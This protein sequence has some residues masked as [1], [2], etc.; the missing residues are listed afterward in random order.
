MAAQPTIVSW[1]SFFSQP[2]HSPRKVKVS[3]SLRFL[4]EVL[5]LDDLHYGVWDG[6]TL[7]LEG[8]K[9]A[10]QRYS[11]E[12]CAWVPDTV[13]S[14]LD[15]GCGTGGNS[16]HLSRQGFDVEGLSPD[17][18]QQRIYRQRTGL[19]FHLRRFQEF[20][21]VRH[22]DLTLMSESAQYVWLDSLFPAVSRVSPGG[23]LLV[24]DYFLREGVEGSMAKSG[25]PL[26]AFLAK[27]RQHDF[28]LL[29][30]EDITERTLPTLDLAHSWV[31]RYVRPSIDIVEASMAHR[32]P[33]LP[34]ILRALLRRPLAK[35][36]EGLQLIDSERFAASKVYMRLLFRHRPPTP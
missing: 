5:R 26:H 9:A 14:I 20:D 36:E 16:L 31:E 21:P 11:R 30:Q 18:Y 23:Y 1:R 35:A 13:G 4:H 8:L 33:W 25:H 34:K 27:A 12:L 32:R 7:D 2:K 15:V 3:T 17:P 28:D 24:C 29:E 19:P 10:Q 22:Y 6:E